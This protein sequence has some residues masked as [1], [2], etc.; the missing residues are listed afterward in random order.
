MSVE[1][2]SGSDLDVSIE[3]E[4][5]TK[6]EFLPVKLDQLSIH[7]NSTLDSSHTSSTSTLDASISNSHKKSVSFSIDL[8]TI[9]TFDDYMMRLAK[10][11]F[12]EEIETD[13]NLTNYL[14]E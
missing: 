5:E 14:K 13:D 8:E 9:Y 1:L 7:S 4:G 2:E 6:G 11:K 12:N 3:F 10:Y